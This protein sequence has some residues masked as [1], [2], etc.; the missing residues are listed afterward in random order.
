MCGYAQLEAFPFEYILVLS[1]ESKQQRCTL[2]C[3]GSLS[4]MRPINIYLEKKF[5]RLIAS[6]MWK[7]IRL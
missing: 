3:Q 1:A 2:Y 7:K 4:M 5:K 6:V